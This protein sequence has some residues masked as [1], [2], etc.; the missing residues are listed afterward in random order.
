MLVVFSET[1]QFIHQ[2]VGGLSSSHH[3]YEFKA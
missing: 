2:L 1:M 3:N